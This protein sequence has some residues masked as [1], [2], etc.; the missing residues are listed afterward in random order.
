MQL[1]ILVSAADSGR[2]F[3]LRCIVR[4]GLIGFVQRHHAGALP[5]LRTEIDAPTG[6]PKPVTEPAPGSAAA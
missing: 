3:D 2:C 5:R 4:E 6:S 1:R